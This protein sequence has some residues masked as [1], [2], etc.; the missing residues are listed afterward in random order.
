MILTTYSN[1]KIVSDCL[2]IKGDDPYIEAERLIKDFPERFSIDN[3][4]EIDKIDGKK[5]LSDYYKYNYMLYDP[6]KQP[7]VTIFRIEN[8]YKDGVYQGMNSVST[9]ML[10]NNCE[11]PE[12]HPLP[13]EDDKLREFWSIYREKLFFGFKS[14]EQLKFWVYKREWRETLEAEGY[15]ISK[16][17]ARGKHG[18]TQSV[19]FNETREDIEKISL[20]SV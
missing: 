20:T 14:I 7:E 18:D 1:L 15:F 5:V 13:S 16:I 17:K 2:E 12:R 19:Y 10:K 3:Y 4:G 8:K 11:N 6:T 9:K